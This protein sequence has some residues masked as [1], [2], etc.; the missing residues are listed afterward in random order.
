MNVVSLILAGG[1]GSR[2]YPLTKVRSKPA[3]PVAGR[4]RLIDIALSNCIHSDVH[5]IFVL[6]QFASESL[7]RHIFTTY[8]FDSFHR[9]RVTLLSAQQ[10]FDN[11]NWYQGTADAVR[12]NLGYIKDPGALVLVLSGD[13]LYRMDY[14]KFVDFHIASGAEISIGVTPIGAGQAPELGVM[15]V[16]GGGRITEFREKPGDPADIERLRV[17]EAVFERFGTPARGR[18]HLASMGIYLFSQNVLREILDQDDSRDFGRE[19]IPRAIGERQVC[20]YFFD[21]YWED[22]GTIRSFFEA[23]MDLTRP[24]PRFNFYDEGRP[25]FTHPRFLP[26]SKILGADV[27]NAILCEGSIVDRSFIRDSIIGI[28]SRI[29]QG[30]RLERTVVMGADFYE[31][32]QDLD[33]NRGQGLPAI[34]LGRGGEIRN[35]IIDK[36]ARIG[37]GVRLVNAANVAAAE[38][39]NYSIVDGIIVVP[40]DAVI[41]DGTVI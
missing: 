16:D 22:I 29:G 20:G 19:V 13:H 21:G 35:A 36:N 10:T 7:H 3:V 18:T 27:G 23:H 34:G 40:K 12:Q 9:D 39:D 8:R 33:R 41:P 1:Q 5:N 2:L 25:I 37:Q 24:L 17:D 38:A 6:T 31:S 26:G 30:V 4:F 15:K 14:R 28:R 11:R 32:R